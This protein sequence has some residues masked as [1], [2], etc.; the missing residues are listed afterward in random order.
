MKTKLIFR[1][2]LILFFVMSISCSKENVPPEEE[3]VFTWLCWTIIDDINEE[4]IPN[5]ELSINYNADLYDF[6]GTGFDGYYKKLISD[7]DG[8]ACYNF[9][10]LKRINSW[11]AS[12]T[13]Y[14][15]ERG[16]GRQ[17]EVIRLIPLE[18]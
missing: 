3:V 11:N 15:E 1:M 17:P 12:A 5:A 7:N 6:F 18:E 16:G 13:G 8:E 9:G 14:I 10:N 2:T 4:P